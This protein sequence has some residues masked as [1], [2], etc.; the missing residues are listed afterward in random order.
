[1]AATQNPQVSSNEHVDEGNVRFTERLRLIISVTIAGLSTGTQQGNNKLL[2][3]LFRDPNQ[4]SRLFV[5]A[6]ALLSYKLSLALPMDE[7]PQQPK[8][9]T[10][11]PAL[12]Q[13]LTYLSGFPLGNDQSP[14]QPV[15]L[16]TRL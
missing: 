14:G 10:W 6:T 4:S 16:T 5:L 3:F 1:L 12:R 9:E 7:Y 11:H 2:S 13:T 15:L 8:L